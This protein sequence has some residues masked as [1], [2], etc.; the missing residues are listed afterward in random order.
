MWTISELS[1]LGR[2]TG[3]PPDISWAPGKE[4]TAGLTSNHTV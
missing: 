4:Y 3:T 1:G 2:G